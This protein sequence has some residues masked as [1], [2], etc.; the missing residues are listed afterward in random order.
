MATENSCPDQSL[1]VT[2]HRAHV[3]LANLSPLPAP[4]RFSA[5]PTY[6]LPKKTPSKKSMISAV[7][8]RA[9][10]D[11]THFLLGEGDG[12]DQASLATVYGRTIC[13][14]KRKVRSI[15]AAFHCLN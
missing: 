4:L 5:D 2:F 6:P 12:I 11:Y 1:G 13:I 14:S 8:G 3:F 15:L 10:P 7:L 9:D